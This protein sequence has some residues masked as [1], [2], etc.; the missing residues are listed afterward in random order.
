MPLN[1]IGEFDH[2]TGLDIV[3]A[4]DAGDTVTHRQH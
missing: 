3:E 2:F 4:V 1:A